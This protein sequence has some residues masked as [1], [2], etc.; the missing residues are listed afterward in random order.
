MRKLIAVVLLIVGL[1]LGGLAYSYYSE[2]T[3]ASNLARFYRN[4]PDEKPPSY[5]GE[6]REQYIEGEL[7]SAERNRNMA[8]LTGVGSLIL[9]A[10]GAVL[11]VF[12]VGRGKPR[13]SSE[14]QLI[15]DQT[16]LGIP[17]TWASVALAQPVTVQYRLLQ[18]ILF[19]FVL[20][21]FGGLTILMIVTNGFNAGV[22]LLL[23]LII[24]FLLTFVLIMRRARQKA[25]YVLDQ[26]G[27]IR[28]DN[29]KFSWNDMKSVDYLM[30]IKRGGSREYL[31]RIELIFTSGEVWL[32]P[33]RVKNLEEIKNL[34]SAIPTVHQKRRA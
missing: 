19:A 8:M 9:I 27:V 26:E 33:L 21:L 4:N 22:V 31:W 23:V 5:T 17:S 20:I 12:S 24:L 10:S 13:G 7:R 34:V 18:K 14:A 30:A 25:A 29:R 16:S 2:S 1:V 28:G 15:Q 6:S 32:I 3:I 11:L